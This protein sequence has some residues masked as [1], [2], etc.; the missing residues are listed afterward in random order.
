MSG[1]TFEQPVTRSDCAPA[2]ENSL[3]DMFGNRPLVDDLTLE[4]PMQA[5]IYQARNSPSRRPE[6]RQRR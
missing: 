1:S 2:S 3:H 6:S 5:A 4:R